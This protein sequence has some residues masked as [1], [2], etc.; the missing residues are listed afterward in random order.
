MERERVTGVTLTRDG[1]TN[2]KDGLKE[3][4]RTGG[5][6]RVLVLPLSSALLLFLPFKELHNFK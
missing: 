5:G 3:E 4:Q 1:R 2:T 6:L